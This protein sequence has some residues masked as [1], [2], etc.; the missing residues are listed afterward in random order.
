D[1]QLDVDVAS[2][3]ILRQRQRDGGT[4]QQEP[5]RAI[6]RQFRI[7]HTCHRHPCHSRI[8]LVQVGILAKGQGG[9]TEPT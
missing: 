9:E 7:Y 1:L 4:W 8:L 6:L 5:V 3:A 2:S